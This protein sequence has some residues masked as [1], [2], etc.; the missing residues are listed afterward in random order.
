MTSPSSHSSLC[1]SALAAYNALITLDGSAS[2]IE[3][4]RADTVFVTA[5]PPILSGK[6]LA[7]HVFDSAFHC[8]GSY[9]Q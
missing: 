9:L 1:A 5:H 4:L 7:S 6:V 8:L 3:L 2:E